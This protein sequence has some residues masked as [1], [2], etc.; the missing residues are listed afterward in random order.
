ML[1]AYTIYAEKNAFLRCAQQQQQGRKETV[2]V[3]FQPKN[4]VLVLD[5][6]PTKPLLYLLYFLSKFFDK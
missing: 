4:D 1:M 5:L 6:L 3:I 2:E